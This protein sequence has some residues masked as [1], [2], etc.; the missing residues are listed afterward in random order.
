MKI[1]NGINELPAPLSESV[2]TI[3]KFDGIH[4]GHRRLI[5]EVMHFSKKIQASSVVMT[6][7]PHPRFVLSPSS[8]IPPFCPL[9]DE[10]DQ[11]DIL[12]EIGIDYLIIEPFSKEL[13]QKTAHTFFQDWIC[14]PFQPRVLV[15]GHDFA[16]GF[17]RQGTLNRLQEMTSHQGIK[18]QIIPPVTLDQHTV[19]TG[20]IRQKLLNND[21]AAAAKF[22]RRPFYLRG[23]LQKNN[24]EY[25]FE[26]QRKVPLTGIFQTKLIL[27]DNAQ[28]SSLSTVT[29]GTKISIQ[30]E[31]I[32]NHIIDK[33]AQLH[34]IKSF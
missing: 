6:F 26:S 25:T 5:S 27:E 17:K 2:M 32:P 1:L 19:S 3:G 11:K 21:V 30:V 15:V 22:L 33:K 29:K 34:F 8:P 9:F 14:Q 18:L 10:Q 16:F 23:T 28:Y 4:L 24:N 31:N 13:A 20:Y 7:F 12:E